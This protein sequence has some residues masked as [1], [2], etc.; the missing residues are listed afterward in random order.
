MFLRVNA[1]VW[2]THPMHKRC[3]IHAQWDAQAGIVNG[4]ERGNAAGRNAL[5]LR[6]CEWA[7]CGRRSRLRA[8]TSDAMG[9]R[10]MNG[11]SGAREQPCLSQVV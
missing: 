8:G 5:L 10:E 7:G 3:T 9:W 4:C 11:Q 6:L 1:A 2:H